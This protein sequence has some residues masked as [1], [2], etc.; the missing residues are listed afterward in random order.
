M[1]SSIF[2]A[3]APGGLNVRGRI[4]YFRF[5]SDSERS[6]GIGIGNDVP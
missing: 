1:T 5:A 4:G 2:R 6:T 3:I